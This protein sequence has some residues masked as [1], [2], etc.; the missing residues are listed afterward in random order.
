MKTGSLVAMLYI[1][2]YQFVSQVPLARSGVAVAVQVGCGHALLLTVLLILSKVD[3]VVQDADL[4]AVAILVWVI[5]S[6]PMQ[7]HSSPVP[8]AVVPHLGMFHHLRETSVIRQEI[9]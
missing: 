8:C 6:A 2:T 7:F 5:S 3:A 4:T 1:R 9:T